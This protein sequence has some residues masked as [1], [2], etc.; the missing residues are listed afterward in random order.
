MKRLFL[1]S[2]LALSALCAPFAKEAAPAPDTYDYDMLVSNIPGVG[3]PYVSGDYVVFTAKRDCRYVGIAFDFEGYTKIHQFQLHKSFDYEG[4]VTDSWFF[5]VLEKPKKLESISYRLVI[6]GLWTTDPTNPDKMYNAE[7][8]IMISH[9]ALP[10]V[11]E[12]ATENVPEGF[13]RFV[14][15]AP[16]G[17]KIRLGGTFTNWDSWIYE[18]TEVS[19]G[20]Y[21]LDL[22]L[23]SGVY[24]YAYYNGISSFID[25]TNP[26]KGYTIDG[27][28]ASKIIVD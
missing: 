27:R 5:Y 24:Y 23:S 15:F 26:L 28:T 7:D 4:Y 19:R 8:S 20:K 25:E 16:S 10:K 6:D 12:V 22:P 18:M 21:Q 3:A 17:Q 14:C 9:V 1:A 2:V 13:T 11:Q